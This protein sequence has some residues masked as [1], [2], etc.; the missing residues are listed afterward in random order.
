MKNKFSLFAMVGLLILSLFVIGAESGCDKSKLDFDTSA[1][2]MGFVEN[3]PP[4]EIN[5]GVGFPIYVKVD[6]FGGYDVSAG[7]AK[8]Y[9]TGV[10][11]NFNNIETRKVSTSTLAKKTEMQPG[12]SEVISFAENA[13]VVQQLPQEFNLSF[14]V[15][16]CYDY[17]TIVQSS[18]CVGK[19]AGTC[20]LEGNKIETGSNTAAPIQVTELTEQVTGNNLYI[21]FK[22]E[23]QGTGQV[24]LVD[25]DCD[26]I[27]ENDINEQLKKGKTNIAIITEQGFTCN[28]QEASAPYSTIKSLAGSS[29]VG[30]TVVCEKEL[31]GT[32]THTSPI[33]I[34]L[35]YK[36]V[37]SIPR[38]ITI[39]P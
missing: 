38:M 26:K 11:Q 14:K 4:I 15:D 16:S 21:S 37:E 22:I 30:Y 3:A 12:G 27:N 23:N 25:S 17:A 6:N 19:I 5:Y 29:Q 2:T 18:I 32:E 28:L 9:L 39:Y 8:F 24:Y 33:Q 10:G 36:Y 13:M 35:N 1:L 7:G 34:L 31:T 20:T